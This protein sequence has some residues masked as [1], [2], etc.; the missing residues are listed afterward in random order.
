M[1][2]MT[3]VV[4]LLLT[5]CSLGGCELSE[6]REQISRYGVQLHELEDMGR[7]LHCGLEELGRESQL[8][9]DSVA[10]NLQ[11]QLPM[12]MPVEER[13]NMVEIRNAGLIRMFEAYPKLPP[14]VQ[15]HVDKAE[16]RD[17]ALASRMRALNDSLKQHDLAVSQF[18]EN[19]RSQLPDSLPEWQGR[20]TIY[21]CD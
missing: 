8:L 14:P 4:S 13:K 2:R 18:L 21:S 19:V 7:S 1:G 10:H 17:Q 11:A 15:Q 3:T 20:L 12:D 5:A 6:N 9:W 16:M